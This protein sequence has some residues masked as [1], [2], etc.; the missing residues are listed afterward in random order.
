MRR[1]S[2]PM[3]H[4]AETAAADEA[5]WGALRQRLAQRGLE[6]GDVSFDLGRLPVPD[7]I[8]AEVYFT[9]VCGFPLL[10]RFS[11]QGRILAAPAYALPGCDGA[12][13]VAFFMVRADDPA[14]GLADMRGRIF[15]CNSLGSNSGMNLP[16]LSIARIADGRPFFAAVSFTGGHAASL[17]RLAEGSID[18]CSID[19]VTW[20]LYE[21]LRPTAARRFRVLGETPRSPSLPY[22]TSIATP[23]RDQ[24]G[25][26]D[27]L[28]DI[29]NDPATADI[30]D[31]LCLA[32][33]TDLDESAYTPVVDYQAEAARLGYPVLC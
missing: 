32:G 11:G 17:D 25:L 12:T 7:D 6:V 16:R 23:V 4:F 33:L 14:T 9:Q 15:G 27:G 10:T 22:V 8:G 1:A 5:F 31:T 24:Q 2:L 18:L 28:H 30:R 20:G 19:C 21:K 26:R 29:M 13:H 3:Y